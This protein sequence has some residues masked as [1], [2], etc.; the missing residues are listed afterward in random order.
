MLAMPVT[1]LNELATVLR[2]DKLDIDQYLG[3]EIAKMRADEMLLRAPL[4]VPKSPKRD[5]NDD[6]VNPHD[7]LVSVFEDDGV[8]AEM[9]DTGDDPIGFHKL[10]D[11]RRRDGWSDTDISAAQSEPKTVLDLAGFRSNF[12]SASV[13]FNE[14]SHGVL[15][16]LDPILRND[17]VLI[18]GGSVL[19]ALTNWGP[20][21]PQGDPGLARTERDRIDARKAR[22]SSRRRWLGKPGDIDIFV[23]TQDATEASQ[24]AQRIFLALTADRHDFRVTRS[25][26]VI[27]IELGR[28]DEPWNREYTKAI[29]VQIVLRLYESPAEVLLGFDVDCCCFGYDGERVWALPRA[30]RSIRYNTNVLNPLHAWPVKASYEYRLIKYA[31]RGFAIAVP[32]MEAVDFDLNKV[33]G[34]PLSQLKGFARLVRMVLAFDDRRMVDGPDFE[35]TPDTSAR[36]PGNLCAWSGSPLEP[37]QRSNHELDKTLRVALGDQEYE[38]LIAGKWLYDDDDDRTMSNVLPQADVARL[39]MTVGHGASAWAQIE[40]APLQTPGTYPY[41][42]PTM[43]LLQIPP[44]LADAWDCAKRSREYLNAKES[45]LDA[46]YFAH[47]AREKGSSAAAETDSAAAAQ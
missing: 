38:R 41:A 16:R 3:P 18:A 23:C 40:V 44:R 28:D 34:V 29:Q 14:V 21:P 36:M 8:V 20:A 2:A 26:G 31:F 12:G 47:A 43:F 30:L 22:Q 7:G 42:A 9:N 32:G 27:N 33:I 45:D 11:L 1:G 19:R 10:L 17:P 24:V 5:S 25:S 13:G 35:E 4:S 37:V 6:L 39:G 15:A 46:R